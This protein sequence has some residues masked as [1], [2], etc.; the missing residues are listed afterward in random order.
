MDKFDTR[1]IVRQAKEMRAE[2]LR[3]IE[4][5]IAAR[6]ARHLRLL[7]GSVA[8]AGEVL[9]PLFSWNPQTAKPGH[10]ASGPSPLA[11]ASLSLRN[12]FSWNPQ[13]H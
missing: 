4:G 1:E 8:N 3:R 6:L 5:L 13:A 9:R 11:R 10:R 12:L 2:E 7:A